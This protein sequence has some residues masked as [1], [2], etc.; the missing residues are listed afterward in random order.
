MELTGRRVL[1]TGASRGIGEATAR[2]AAAAGAKVALAA[3]SEAA[4]KELA[5]EVAGTAH[6]T[7]LSD[8]EAVAGLVAEVESDGVPVDVLINNAGVDMGGAFIDT[9]PEDLEQLYRVNLLTP[10]QLCR[11]VLP[12]MLARG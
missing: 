5:A 2:A 1:I 4:L 10:V 12:G 9:S 8:P 6:P 3:R 7:D 11:K